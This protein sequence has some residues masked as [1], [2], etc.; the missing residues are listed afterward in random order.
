MVVAPQRPMEALA[1]AAAQVAAS[2][3]LRTALDAI[4]RAAVEATG[5]DL[6]VL[7]VVD[8]EG[9]LVAHAQAPEGS[10]LAAEVAGTRTASELVAAGQVPEPTRRSAERARAAGVLAVPARAAGRMVGSVELV[11]IAEDFDADEFATAELVAAQVA[12][13]VRTLAPDTGATGAR[14]KWLELAGEALAAG[15]DA[16]RAAQQAVRLAVETSGAR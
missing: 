9:A 2:S 12:L 7:R 15:G 3:D 11:R 1:R 4:A 16:Q 14:A 5:A 8:A 6:A 13:A 10:S